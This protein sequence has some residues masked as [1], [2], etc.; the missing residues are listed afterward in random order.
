MLDHLG[1]VVGRQEGLALAA[2]RHGHEAHEVGEPGEPRL[3]ELG[4]L[5]PVMVDVP[6]FVGDDQVVA[7]RST[8]SWKIMK[9]VIS[10]SSMRRI[11]WKALRSCSPDSSSMWRNSLASRALSGWMRLAVGRQQARHRD[12]APASRPAG[13]AGACAARGRWRCRAG[14]GRGRSA[15]RD[16]APSSA[17]GRGAS[18]GLGAAR[19]S[20]RSRKSLI[21]GIAL[22]GIAAE[23]I[24][25]AA[26]DG[27]ELAAAAARPPACRGHGAGSGR[28][29]HGSPARGSGC[30]G[31]SPR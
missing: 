16:R 28:R 5:V 2:R 21:S 7:A 10:S 15:R 14:R 23:R 4:M 26:G 6:G 11:A 13:R 18:A 22:G 30:G 24:V 27:H 31:T 20:R 29:R 9:F 1:I 8:A 19:P 12:P 3:L 25:A 17:R